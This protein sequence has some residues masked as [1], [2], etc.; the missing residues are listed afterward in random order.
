MT[1]SHARRAAASCSAWVHSYSA[2]SKE[3]GCDLS[4]A[5]W[6]ALWRVTDWRMSFE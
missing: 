5:E 4:P 6:R 2:L 1:R 3:T